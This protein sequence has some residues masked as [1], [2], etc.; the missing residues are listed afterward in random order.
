V[1]SLGLS[2]A[3]IKGLKSESDINH[4]PYSFSHLCERIR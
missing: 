3:G 2:E 1:N 4:S